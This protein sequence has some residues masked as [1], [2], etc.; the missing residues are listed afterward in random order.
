VQLAPW[1]AITPDAQWLHDP[2]GADD[3]PDAFVLA[4]RVRVQL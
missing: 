1:L 2:G 4:L 3:A